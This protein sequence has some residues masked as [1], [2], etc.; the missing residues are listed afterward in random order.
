MLEAGGPT[1]LDQYRAQTRGC[2]FEP[3]GSRGFGG[4]GVRAFGFRGLR[5]LGFRVLGLGCLE[6]RVFGV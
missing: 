5:G 3:R 4:F 6:F 2:C 1:G